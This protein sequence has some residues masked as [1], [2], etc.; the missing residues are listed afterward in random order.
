MS[1]K[2]RYTRNAPLDIC[3]QEQF[4]KP[5]SAPVKSYIHKKEI[6]NNPRQINVSL[7][8]HPIFVTSKSRKKSP[9]ANFKVKHLIMHFRKLPRT[10]SFQT[11]SLISTITKLWTSFSNNST[12][13]SFLSGSFNIP[14]VFE[15]SWKFF[16]Y[17]PCTPNTFFCAAP[18]DSTTSGQF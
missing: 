12:C 14:N 6:L 5:C 15:P 18:M 3:S 16:C 2:R 11:N 10:H 13:E 17:T 9:H 1:S 8:N 7:K 4:E